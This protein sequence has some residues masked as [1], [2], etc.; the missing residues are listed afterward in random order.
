MIAN[1][2]NR[3]HV[4]TA[5]LVPVFLVIFTLSQLFGHLIPPAATVAQSDSGQRMK[6]L[7]GSLERTAPATHVVAFT[8][9]GIR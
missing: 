4:Q 7:C 5:L 8:N 3:S 1:V 9:P 6:C 2:R